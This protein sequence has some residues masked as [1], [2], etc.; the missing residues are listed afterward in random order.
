[1]NSTIYLSK[2]KFTTE[3]HAEV[4]KSQL[5]YDFTALA[6]AIKEWTNE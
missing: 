2:R 6:A 1:M 4:Q 3:E 5:S